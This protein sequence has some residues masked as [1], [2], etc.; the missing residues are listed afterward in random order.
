[1]TIHHH[2][3]TELLDGFSGQFRQRRVIRAIKPRKP[4]LR[5]A[6]RKLAGVDFR[7][8]AHDAGNDA[9]AGGD[10]GAGRV[11]GDIEGRVEHA[12][13]EFATCSVDV[14]IGAGEFRRDQ[15]RSQTGDAGK[16]FID[17]SVFGAAQGHGIK[18]A[19]RDQA[20]RIAPPGMA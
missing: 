12:A 4:E 7:A 1:M 16:Q 11:D 19:L 10:A 14:A 20:L 8:I 13:V 2:G 17:E 9:K 3:N 5:F 15:G 6:R 18:P